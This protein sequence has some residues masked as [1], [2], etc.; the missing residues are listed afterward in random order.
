VDSRGAALFFTTIFRKKY[1]EV[2]LQSVKAKKEQALF[3]QSDF[4]AFEP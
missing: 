2:L 4:M 3:S 1:K